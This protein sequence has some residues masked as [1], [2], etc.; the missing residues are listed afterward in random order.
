MNTI[1][2]HPATP[3]PDITIRPFRENDV[4]FVISRQLNLYAAEYGFTSET[5]RSYLT[6]GVHDF[7]NRFDSNR[8]CMY[9]L[10]KNGVPSGCV[11]VAHLDKATAQLRFFFLEPELRG[12]GAGHILL[13]MGVEFCR[14]KRYERVFLWTF[15]TLMAARHLYAGKG[16]RVTETRENTEW[17]DLILEECWDLDLSC[18]T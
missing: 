4:D 9:I 11:A 2:R 16:F 18:S 7:V 8:S 6:G 13:D 17:G 15:S 10:E 5:W 3:A 12:R 14:E 1:E